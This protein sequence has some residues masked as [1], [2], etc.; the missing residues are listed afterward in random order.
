MAGIGFLN[1]VHGQ[2]TDGISDKI[3]ILTH[4]YSVLLSNKKRQKPLALP[5]FFLYI[6]PVNRIDSY[7]VVQPAIP[8]AARHHESR[9]F[10][11]GRTLSGK[12]FFAAE[13]AHDSIGND[14]KNGLNHND[15]LPRHRQK[16]R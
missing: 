6:S 9:S 12:A 8:A 4:A 15:S 16:A 10:F 7:T 11:Q 3:Q 5:A 13:S 14:A 1:S 2:A